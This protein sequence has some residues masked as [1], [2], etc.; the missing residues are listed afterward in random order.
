MRDSNFSS[1]YFYQILNGV[2]TL[3]GWYARARTHTHTQSLKLFQLSMYM[4]SIQNYSKLP[5]ITRKLPITTFAILKQFVT[6]VTKE[7]LR[8]L[9]IKQETVTHKK[10]KTF[11]Y[12][13][14]MLRAALDGGTITSDVLRHKT[15]LFLACLSNSALTSAP[16]ACRST[17][18]SAALMRVTNWRQSPPSHSP[19]QTTGSWRHADTR[20]SLLSRCSL[21]LPS[22]GVS[23]PRGPAV[24][25]F[26]LGTTPVTNNHTQRFLYTPFCGYTLI[27]GTIGYDIFSDR[28]LLNE[29]KNVTDAVP[30]HGE[31]NAEALAI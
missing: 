3:T 9:Q 2:R 10:N 21:G 19:Q 4:I 12:F 29:K 31:G 25:L 26:R 20:F 27:A 24:P 22:R 28:S 14:P 23:S 17:G 16:D 5:K 7:K 1:A 18:A 15:P 11:S 13:F 8:F 30:N 6:K